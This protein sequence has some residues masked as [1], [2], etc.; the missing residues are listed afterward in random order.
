MATAD[1]SGT[2]GFPQGATLEGPAAREAHSAL[3]GRLKRG[4]D[5]AAAAT[6]LIVFAPLIVFTMIAVRLS[7]GGPVLFGHERIGLAGQRF[8]CWKFRTMRLDAAAVLERY[9]AANP[10]AR[11][12]WQG[13][14][15]LRHDPR[16][17][18]LGRVLRKY[19]VDELPQLFNVLKGDMSLVG[20]RPVIEDELVRYGPEAVRYCATR[21]GITGLWQVSGRSDT[22]FPHRVA[23]DARYVAG[24]SFGRDIGILVRTIPVVLGARGSY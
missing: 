22:S 6:I 12:E 7:M 24:W 4:F 10:A 9:L 14:R 3:G 8:T 19:S 23:L 16:I 17:T 11:A 20:P 1:Q 13:T 21:P 5:I 2:I 18:P 15:K